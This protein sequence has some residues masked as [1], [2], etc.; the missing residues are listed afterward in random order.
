MFT[1][2]RHDEEY[3]DDDLYLTP[4]DE[5]GLRSEAVEFDS[6]RAADEIRDWMEYN[7]PYNST[8]DYTYTVEEN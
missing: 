1:I 5:Y 8:G 7:S 4:D 3:P 6:R 2:R